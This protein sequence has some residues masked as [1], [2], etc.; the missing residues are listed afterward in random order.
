M[1]AHQSAGRNRPSG[2][3]VNPCGVCIHEF[4]DRI[5]NALSRVPNATRQVARKCSPRGTR[6][7]PNSI[8]PRNPASRKKAVSTS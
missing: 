7:R 3:R 2:V 8:T 4:T 5:Q 1:I 6:S